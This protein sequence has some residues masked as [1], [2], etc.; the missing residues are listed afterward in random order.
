M[1]SSRVKISRPSGIDQPISARKLSS[2][3]GKNPCVAEPAERRPRVLALRDLAAVLVAQEREVGERRQRQVEPLVEQHVLRGAGDPLLAARDVADLHQVVVDDDGQVV[4]R[5]AVALEQHLI[6]DQAVLELDPAADQ[7]VEARSRRRRAPAS[8]PPAARTSRRG[9]AAPASVLPKQRRS[10]LGGSLRAWASSRMRFEPLGRA[11]AAVGVAGLD[12]VVGVLA[13]D[14][15]PLGLAV[16][17]VRAADVRALVPG[18]AGPAQH[19]EDVLLGRVDVTA[20]V[21]V[22]DAEDE[23][24]AVAVGERHVEQRHVGRADVRIA[25]RGGGDAETDGSVFA[26]SR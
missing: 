2:A 24:A 12:Q 8:G 6:V 3:S 20:L 11:P 5:E 7:V 22:L 21:R 26:R 23:L 14:R 4:G 16:R 9:R 1:N 15:E 17:A 18:Q 25:G 10:Y 19:V 13:V